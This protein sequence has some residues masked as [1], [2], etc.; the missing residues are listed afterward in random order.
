MI[1]PLPSDISNIPLQGTLNG[2]PHIQNITTY[3]G[4]W[5]PVILEFEESKQLLIKP[6]DRIDW[7]CATASGSDYFTFQLGAALQAPIVAVSG[8]ELCWISTSADTVME[9]MVGR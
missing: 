5:Y 8:T 3:S 9:I 1:K 6:R 7:Y 2:I 4:I